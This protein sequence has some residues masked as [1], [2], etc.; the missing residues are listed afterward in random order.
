MLVAAS[1]SGRNLSTE[2]R[3]QTPSSSSAAAAAARPAAGGSGTNASACSMPDPRNQRVLHAAVA[4]LPNAGKSTLLNYMV[5]DKVSAVS[6]KRHTTRENTLGV[7]TVGRT[8]VFFHDTPGFVSH[9]ERDDYKPALSAESREAI[10]AVDL[11]LLLVDASK[12]VT[13]R[14]L[15]SLTGLLERVLRSRCEVFLVLNK[16]D[17]VHPRHRLLATTDEIMDRAQEIM[18]RIDSEREQAVAAVDTSPRHENGTAAAAAAAA[19]GS[20]NC[21]ASNGSGVGERGQE[22]LFRDGGK[23]VDDHVTVFMV[24]AKTGHGVEDV[25]DF[26]VHRARPGAWLFGPDETTN[27]DKRSRVKE[28]VRE[29]LYKHLY[30]EL[31]YQITTHIRELS[32][33]PDNS[34]SVLQELRL[35][36]ASQKPIVLGKLKYIKKDVEWDLRKLFGTRVDARFFVIV[37]HKKG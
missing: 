4:G 13:K 16:S 27:K 19:A 23:T 33:R 14:G 5:G 30:K 28:I 22:P 7:M 32:R 6:T 17:L 26:L 12:D 9:E 3:P 37:G 29:G 35:D 21:G 20:G 25:V 15:R 31:P 11:T 36:R 18:D 24:S 1:I 8:Q 10:A 2:K 34:V